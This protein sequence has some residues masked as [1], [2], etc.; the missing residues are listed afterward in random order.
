MELEGELPSSAPKEI[1]TPPTNEIKT[2]IRPAAFKKRRAVGKT[3]LQRM[4]FLRDT[5]NGKKVTRR[6]K[7]ND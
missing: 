4:I 7:K 2:A 5:M 3:N 6:R 1:T